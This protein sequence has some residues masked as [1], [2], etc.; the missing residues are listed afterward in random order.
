MGLLSVSRTRS[1]AS[2][3]YDFGSSG[4]GTWICMCSWDGEI[5]GGIPG[6]LG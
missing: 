4:L 2:S 6:E 1:L 3:S 5:S